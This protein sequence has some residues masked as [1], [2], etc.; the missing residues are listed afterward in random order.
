MKKGIF[1]LLSVFFSVF[2]F[3]QKSLVIKNVAVIDVKTG[4]VNKHLT[5]VV[6][7]NKIISVGSKAVVPP[8]AFA[9]DGTGKYLIPGLWD[10][11][12]HALTDKRYVYTFPLLIANGITGVR[13]MASNLPFEQVNQIRKDVENGKMLG[14]RFGAIAYRLFDGP[15]TQFSN[16][17]VVITTPEQGREFVRTYKQSGA[18]F[19]KTYNLLSREVYLAIVDEAKKQHIPLEGHVPFSMTPAEVSNLGQ[20]SIEHNFGVPLGCSQ[21]EDELRKQLLAQPNLWGQIEAKASVNYDTS[22]AHNLYKLFVRN[23]TWSCPTIVIFWPYRL[24]S[25]STLR[26]DSLLQYIPK[27][28][29]DDWHETFMQRVTKAVPDPTDRKIRNDIRIFIVGEMYRAGVRMLAGTDMPNPYTLPGFSLHQELELLVEAGLPPIEALK[30][31]TLNPA[32]FLHKE[33]ELGTVEK[34]KIADL[35]LLDANPLEN[36]SNTKTINAVV[37]NGKLLKRKDLDELLAKE[38]EFAAK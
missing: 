24:G 29:R 10:M 26:Q 32:I 28:V 2:C 8:N 19:I 7:G 36:I 37:V 17:A 12:A 27:S 31:A 20:R 3:S 25:D 13:E 34:G 21:K 4:K 14:P 6:T 16:V 1:I 30:A 11:H 18:D 23:G 22:K 15:G 9:I 38:K 5:V 33:K 35:V